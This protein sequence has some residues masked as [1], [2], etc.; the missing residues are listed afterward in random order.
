MSLK[1][2]SP[3]TDMALQT[4]NEQEVSP[5]PADSGADASDDELGGLS[6]KSWQVASPQ[7]STKSS[8]EQSQGHGD[9]N[10]ADAAGEKG[11]APPVPIQKRRRVT[12][13]STAAFRRVRPALV[14][15]CC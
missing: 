12:R 15:G 8:S 7:G 11:D 14:L 1:V 6:S 4:S 3:T 5:D 2:E 13:V 10:A 9:D